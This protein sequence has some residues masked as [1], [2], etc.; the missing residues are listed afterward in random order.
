VLVIVVLIGEIAL[1]ILGCHHTQTY[2]AAL[3]LS[4]MA[5][6]LVSIPSKKK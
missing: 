4:G 3:H 6:Q 1:G 2:L 5:Q